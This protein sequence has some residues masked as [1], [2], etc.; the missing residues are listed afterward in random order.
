MAALLLGADSFRGPPT[1]DRGDDAPYTGVTIGG[2]CAMLL[3]DVVV[4]GLLAAFAFAGDVDVGQ[5]LKT[6]RSLRTAP[7]DL[8]LLKHEALRRRDVVFAT[9]GGDEVVAVDGVDLA[10][11][12]NECFSLL[13]HNGAGKTTTIAT[14]VGLATPTSGTASVSGR[15]LADMTAIRTTL[16]YCAQHDTFFDDL[17]VEEHLVLA[18]TL[19]RAAGPAADAADAL[20]ETRLAAFAAHAPPHLSGGMRRKVSTALALA[21][22]KTKFV[23]LDEPT[24][25]TDQRPATIFERF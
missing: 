20:R 13:G 3:V 14:L 6:L 16:G 23:V 5:V 10:F 9:F 11:Y 24:A 19:R 15:D 17:T 2:I 21:G 4:Y 18:A 7:E 1:N 22:A 25:G 12:E 8:A